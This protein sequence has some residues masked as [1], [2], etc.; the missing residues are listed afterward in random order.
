MID[1]VTPRNGKT[2]VATQLFDGGAMAS[3]GREVHGAI[4]TT[5]AFAG[6]D[7]CKVCAKRMPESPANLDYHADDAN[8]NT[9]DRLSMAQI[10]NSFSHGWVKHIR[11]LRRAAMNKLVA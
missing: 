1:I 9:W 11:D 10:R 2:H 8:T 3:C 7:I 4:G 6:N 5:N